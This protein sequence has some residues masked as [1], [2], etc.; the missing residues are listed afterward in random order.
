MSHLVRAVLDWCLLSLPKDIPPCQGK[1]SPLKLEQ[2]SLL[3]VISMLGQSLVF[4]HMSSP[5]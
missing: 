3:C 5:W 2:H 4:A 1:A